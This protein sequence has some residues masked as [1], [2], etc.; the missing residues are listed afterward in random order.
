MYKLELLPI[1]I[2][3]IKDIIYYI[4]FTLK[5]KTAAEKLS[6]KIISTFDIISIFPY[7]SSR[8]FSDKLKNEY[9]CLRVNNYII[10]YL[11]D[12]SKKIVTI[13]RMCYYKRKI[14]NL[15]TY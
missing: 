1:A 15:L 5:N 4:S 14:D 8:F 7:G 13:T 9:R 11:I 3:D 12:E 10:V 6:K 2:N